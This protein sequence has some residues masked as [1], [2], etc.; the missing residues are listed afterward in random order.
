MKKIIFVISMLLTVG[1]L[2]ACSSD[3]KFDTTNIST[4]SFDKSPDSPEDSVDSS[5]LI[6][7]IEGFE[8]YAEIAEFFNSELPSNTGDI[9]GPSSFFMESNEE[10]NFEH[11]C[12]I[13]NNKEDFEKQYHGE[14]LLPNIDFEKNTLIIGKE[15]FPH[16]L[17]KL[18]RKELILE[19]GKLLLNLYVSEPK[20][21]YYPAAMLN[22]YFWG[23]YPKIESGEVS[24][25]VIKIEA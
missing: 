17:Y 6:L 15:Y 12:I 23:L 21:G 25:N 16:L 24:V 22:M 8:G 18:E 4:T 5:G 7:P 10:T 13:I 20:D 14:R 9:V 11:K 19:K 2:G 3:D 1:L